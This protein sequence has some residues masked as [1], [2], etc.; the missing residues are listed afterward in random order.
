M[1][2][3]TGNI[4][5]Q[6]IRRNLSDSMSEITVQLE[7]KIMNEGGEHERS[8]CVKVEFLVPNDICG[9]ESRLLKRASEIASK[10]AKEMVRKAG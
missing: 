8:Q 2:E 7:T 9:N 5:I 10:A 4:Q 1:I 6:L 3:E